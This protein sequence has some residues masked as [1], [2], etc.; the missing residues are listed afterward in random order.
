MCYFRWADVCVLV[1]QSDLKNWKGRPG[2]WFPARIRNWVHSSCSTHVRT[3]SWWQV[4]PCLFSSSYYWDD[5]YLDFLLT[6]LTYLLT[7]Y[8]T[9]ISSPSTL[10]ILCGEYKTWLGVTEMWGWLSMIWGQCGSTQSPL[11]CQVEETA[12]SW[13]FFQQAPIPVCK[14]SSVLECQKEGEQIT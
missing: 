1:V 2:L 10:S 11:Q 7:S 12:Q 4:H 14:T 6:F 9:Y 8:F 13:V 5:S 3:L